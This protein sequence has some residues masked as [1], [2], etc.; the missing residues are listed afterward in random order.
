M[1]N[2]SYEIT[3]K[4]ITVGDVIESLKVNL[5]QEVV[6]VGTVE[7]SIQQNVTPQA[8]GL[9]A[10][11]S[12]IVTNAGDSTLSY[13]LYSDICGP[14][15]E[16]FDGSEGGV[17]TNYLSILGLVGD[18]FT[19]A[20]QTNAAAGNNFQTP[21]VPQTGQGSNTMKYSFFLTF[22]ELLQKI[23]EFVIPSIN[24]SK[25]LNIDYNVAPC[26]IYPYQFSFDPRICLV[27]PFFLDKFSFNTDAQYTSGVTAGGTSGSGIINYYPW[28]NRINNFGIQ[29]NKAIYGDIMNIY[30]N[31][32]FITSLLAN[33]TNEK[34]EIYLFKFLQ[35]I[36]DGINDAMGGVNN[37]E[38]ILTRDQI[39]TFIEQNPIPGIEKTSAYKS[40]FNRD[41]VPFELFGYNPNSG[42]QQS[43]NFVRDFGFDT[44]ITPNLASMITIG[45]T[46][47]KT[48]TKNYDG[49]A[50]SKWNEGLVDRFN[51]DY[52]DPNSPDLVPPSTSGSQKDVAPLTLDQYGTISRHFDGSE[53]DKYNSPFGDTIDGAFAEW[54]GIKW[55]ERTQPK[56]EFGGDTKEGIRDVKNCPITKKNYQ[57]VTWQEYGNRVR[58]YLINKALKEEQGKS[59]SDDLVNFIAYCTH[60]FGGKIN[61]QPVQ[62][63]MYFKFDDAFIKIGKNSFKGWVNTISNKIYQESGQPSNTTGFIPIDLNLTCDGI[64]GIKIYNQ[65]AIRQEFLPPQYPRALKFV[66][67]QVNHKIENNDWSTNLHTISTA[68]TK[69]TVLTAE[70]FT[71][72]EYDLSDKELLYNTNVAGSPIT[73]VAGGDLRDQINPEKKGKQ[74]YKESPLAKDFIAKGLKNGVNSSMQPYLVDTGEPGNSRC[75]QF[76]NQENWHLAAAPAQAWQRWKADALASGYNIGIT[77]GY[78]SREYQASFGSGGGAAK[79]GSSPHGWGGAVDL[80]IKEPSG[81]LRH[82]LTQRSDYQKKRFKYNGKTGAGAK[83]DRITDDWKIVA[84]LGA[85]YGFFNPYRLANN[86]GAKQLDEAWHFEYWG[87]ADSLPAPVPN[88]QPELSSI[89]L[90]NIEILNQIFIDYDNIFNLRDNYGNNGKALLLPAKGVLNDDESKG[91]EILKAFTIKSTSSLAKLIARLQNEPGEKQKYGDGKDLIGDFKFWRFNVLYKKMRGGQGNDTAYF[92]YA[93]KTYKIDTD[94]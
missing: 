21:L 5:P 82:Q 33:E 93:N 22:R 64:S 51:L 2:G 25:I 55:F 48:P 86:E 43:S 23:E 47:E 87:P 7:Q 15:I 91:I 78:R 46:A 13:S 32:D 12:A 80:W 70:T 77:N 19:Q 73:A 4:L 62:T 6:D 59:A 44:K 52:I 16:K 67:S 65:L 57:N 68:N 92:R 1:P 58:N 31:Y 50:F 88:E 20:T 40:V 26:A 76:N 39:I 45:A 27:K 36:C 56:T 8:T 60:A 14:N 53:I 34:G 94:F 9:V 41:P 79:P 3:L 42:G 72:V 17:K 63:P 89:Q 49:T 74:Y 54:S 90:A 69:N 35:K 85:R 29:D 11:N 81:A 10:A 84:T 38:C 28:L 37:I 18:Q 83:L 30:L 24:D 71:L 66:I 75:K 61:N